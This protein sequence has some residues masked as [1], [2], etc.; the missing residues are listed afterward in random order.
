MF[1]ES[2]LLSERAAQEPARGG[3]SATEPESIPLDQPHPH[4]ASVPADTRGGYGPLWVAAAMTAA[5]GLVMAGASLLP[6]ML[7]AEAH[8]TETTH[9]AAAATAAEAPLN[10]EA[11]TP[12][13]GE[14]RPQPITSLVNPEWVAETAERLGIPQRALAAYAGASIAMSRE[15]PGCGLGWNT[16]AGIGWV[17]SQHGTLGGGSLAMSGRAVPAIV[18]I[19]L[20]GSGGTAPVA[21]TDGGVIDGD[22][23]WDRA[24]GPMQFIPS[25]WS[26]YR[27][28]GDGDGQT[29]PQQIDDAALA[30]AR[31]LCDVGG[32]MTDPERWIAAVGAYNAP[33]DYIN[34]VADAATEYGRL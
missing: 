17:E 14:G 7:T 25:T 20:D 15:A 32:D 5:G 21:D 28:D 27:S 16:L 26:T 23:C 19:P 31:Y 11:E 13:P 22:A 29:D 6:G 2:P 4:D 10:T 24:V 34:Q 9:A 18:G 8:P 12:V 1:D 3:H 33:V 30:A